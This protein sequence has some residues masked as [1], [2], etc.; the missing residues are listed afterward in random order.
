MPHAVLCV[1][2]NTAGYDNIPALTAVA[3]LA[4][5][6][7]TSDLGPDMTR[8]GPAVTRNPGLAALLAA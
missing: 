3:I 2:D 4:S 1:D 7:L 6:D 8:P 5:A